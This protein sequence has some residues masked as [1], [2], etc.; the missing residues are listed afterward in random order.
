VVFLLQEQNVAVCSYTPYNSYMNKDLNGRGFTLIELLVVISII[1][2][3]SSIAL[4]YIRSSRNS[5]ADKS[6]K[7]AMKQVIIQA[8]NYRDSNPNYGV[9]ISS[10]SSGVFGDSR[11]SLIR[12]NILQNAEVAASMVCYTSANGNLWALSISALRGGGSWCVDN[13][14][15]FKATLAQN[16][17]VCS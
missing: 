5:A 1:S 9:S 14:G 4:G 6:V 7:V 17:G 11:L 10:C 16:T 8:E 3:L 15:S 2:V 13:S 12:E